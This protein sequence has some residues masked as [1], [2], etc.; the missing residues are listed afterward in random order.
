[1]RQATLTLWR[2]R[3]PAVTLV[4][5]AVLSAC[6]SDDDSPATQP[7]STP[8]S[9]EAACNAFLGR[10]VESAVVTRA[11]LVAATADIPEHCVVYG[12]MPQDLDFEVRMPTEWN[13]R[14][15]F[16]GGGGFDGIIFTPS[17]LQYSPG[18]SKAGYATVSSNH[19][20]NATTTPGATFAL[21]PQMLAEYAHL[22]VPRLLG[23]VKAILRERY[24]TDYLGTK[25]VYEG[26]SGG[27]RQGLIQ[28]QRYP[29]L[30]DGVISR[31]P[32]NAYT[33]QFLHYQKRVQALLQPGAALSAAKIKAIDNATMAKCDALDGLA[34][35]MIGRPDAC[36][37]DPA[38]LACTGAETDSCLT[39]AQVQSARAF[40][41][42]TSVAN[43]R[44]TWPGFPPGGE[45]EFL[46]W[47]FQGPTLL[48]SGYINYMVLQNPSVDWLQV[49][50]AAYTS[51]IDQLV[52]LIDA[53]DPDLSRFKSRGGKL[54]LWTGLNDWLI[55]A[56]NATDYYQRVVAS[57]GGQAAANEFVEYY[58]SPSVQHCYGGTG[59]DKIDF[60]TPMFEWIEKGTKPSATT[61]VATQMTAP[62]GTTPFARPLCQ[63]PQYPRYV[64]G[65]PNVAS[66]F[67]CTTP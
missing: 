36:N 48:G 37:F 28:A 12:E 17:A 25:M 1:M 3:Y 66:S 59:A 64:S 26:C 5:A 54:I 67:T 60:V 10:S 18:M 55:T 61:I 9:A 53:V 27:G 24:G 56:N 49:D 44:Y 22:A 7:A 38:E 65:D 34:D 41:E 23:S 58:T 15:V 43:G 33:P 16:L 35:K 52:T 6:G 40:Y 21:D 11:S 45:A 2:H 31:A 32:A 47:S 4:A 62:A 30:F 8:L 13:R 46:G 20:H 51:R 42:P 29:D 50:P 14:T 57:S 39:P 19:G 63:Y